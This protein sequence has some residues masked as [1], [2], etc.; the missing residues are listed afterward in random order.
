[1]DDRGPDLRP[2]VE[3]RPAR[4]ADA[5]A[6]HVLEQRCFST[7]RLSLRQTRYHLRN[8]RAL[9]MVA[10][11]GETLVGG[12]FVFL[13][14][15]SGRARLYSLMIA[16]E[17][18]GSG[19]GRRLHEAIE[20]RLVAMGKDE[21]RLEVRTDNPAAIRLYEGLG[22]RRFASRSGYYQDGGDAWRYRKALPAFVSPL[23]PAALQ[24][25]TGRP[26]EVL[27]TC[28]STNR[29]AREY[30]ASR[31]AQGPLT[32]PLP[33][34]VA[35]QQSAGRGRLGRSWQAEPGANL[36]F[37]VLVAPDLPLPLA[38]RAVLCLAAALAAEL[39]VWL[40]W[41][42]DLVDEQD[43][44]LCGILAEHEA[45]PHAGRIGCLVVGIG[46][47]VNQLR[48]PDL[49]NASSLRRRA[50]HPLDRQE[51]LIR[52]LRALDRADLSSPQALDAWRQRS[53]TLGRRVSVAGREGLATGIREDGALLVDDVPVL[54]GDV[55]LMS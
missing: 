28:D 7:D 45:G 31:L 37:S 40:K 6:L 33:V 38:P 41:P 20:A 14:A 4:A 17:A 26:V 12:A 32:G 8:P 27:P 24:A 48:F 47:N 15:G 34:F 18:R 22:Y 43:H 1:M 39:G 30:A 9:V 13:R 52:I 19:L 2:G 23:D 35:E 21:L 29:L 51:L 11:Q 46:L 53:R 44:K 25:A 54:T 50:G 55:E 42:N 49:P 3:V 5:R 36:L 16:P 10:I